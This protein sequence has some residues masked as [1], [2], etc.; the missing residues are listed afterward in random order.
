MSDVLDEIEM[1]ELLKCEISTVQ[2]K[3]RSGELPGIKFGRSWVFPRTAVLE[4]LHKL[5]LA[6]RKK[7]V[8]TAYFRKPPKRMPMELPR[9]VVQ[10]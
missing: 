10:P 4:V 5:A 3:A 9:L 7:P 1:A 8:L 2:D 6:D